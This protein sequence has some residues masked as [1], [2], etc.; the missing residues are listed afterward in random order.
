MVVIFKILAFCHWKIYPY[1]VLT[2]YI[3]PQFLREKS[4]KDLTEACSLYG[5]VI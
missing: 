1:P 2:K 3:K 4:S 5:L